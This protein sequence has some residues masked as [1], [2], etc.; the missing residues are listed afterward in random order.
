L[1]LIGGAKQKPDGAAPLKNNLHNTM[2]NNHQELW[3]RVGLD[4]TSSIS[5]NQIKLRAKAILIKQKQHLIYA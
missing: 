2:V 3:D 4:T 1:I 5:M